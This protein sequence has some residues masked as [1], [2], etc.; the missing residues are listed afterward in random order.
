MLARCRV[1]RMTPLASDLPV[2]L[3]TSLKVVQV[4]EQGLV[5]QALLWNCAVLDG[6]APEPSACLS[7]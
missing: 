1:A 5:D 7:L 4:M 3:W 6:E 2:E